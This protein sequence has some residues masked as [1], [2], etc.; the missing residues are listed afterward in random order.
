MTPDEFIARWK[1]STLGERQAAQPH[2]LNLCQ[3][4][5]DRQTMTYLRAAARS[6]SGPKR[7]SKISTGR[8]TPSFGDPPPYNVVGLHQDD[9]REYP[10]IG[11]AT[12]P[13][14]PRFGVLAGEIVHHLRSSLDHLIHALIIKNGCT[15]SNNNQ[16]PI[17]KAAKDL[18]VTCSDT[19][20]NGISRLAKK[21][22][23]SVQHYTTPAPEDTLLYVINHYDILDKHRLLVTVCTVAEL[24]HQITIG[25]DEAIAS[26]PDRIGKTPNIIRFGEPAPCRVTEGGVQLFTI[27]L[28]EP[29]PEFHPGANFVPQI[30][31]ENCGRACKA[32]VRSE[33][34]AG[35]DGAVRRGL[36]LQAR[37][38]S[39]H[40]V[41]PVAVEQR[42]VRDQRHRLGE[43]L[44]DQ[45]AV[46]P[47]LV[48]AGDGAG[49]LGV[50][51]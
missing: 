36:F 51:R 11:Y 27:G 23:R 18:E 28:A 4:L 42:L 2:F 1:L 45:H 43:R 20:M 40:P 19:R 3:L 8:S 32:A 21:I 49:P 29:A 16:F 48:R 13:V 6:W 30:A 38:P 47:V 35:G 14:P 22:I 41:D 31:F 5:G 25:A 17:C 50:G 26:R 34:G 39:P 33:S 15:A 24:G 44:G 37:S 9:G 7:I 46:E 10:F 12:A